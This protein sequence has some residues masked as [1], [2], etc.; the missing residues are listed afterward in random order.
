M[1]PGALAGPAPDTL[2]VRLPAFPAGSLNSPAWR[3][4]DGAAKLP[5]RCARAGSE[6]FMVCYL[7]GTGTLAVVGFAVYLIWHQAIMRLLGLVGTATEIALLLGA[8]AA[9]AI[10][11]IWTARVIRR[12]RAQA[13]ACTTCRFRCQQALQA[14][15]NLLVNRVD[16]RA[17][18]PAP[19]RPV[20]R[21]CQPAAPSSE[22]SGRRPARPRLPSP[23]LPAR[24]RLPA[25]PYPGDPPRSA[26][27]HPGLRRS[28][29]VQMAAGLVGSVAVPVAGRLRGSSL[30]R[31][32]L[33]AGRRGP[34]ID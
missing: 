28:S 7:P 17:L 20:T 21:A 30:G 10:A 23:W 31:T 14:R 33:G 9:V 4:I 16:R 15:P 13:G 3:R 18:P 24:P 5:R 12:R 1:A 8:A 26:S 34:V 29:V 11:L 25:R 19:S 2:A 32:G 22:C 6:R 27:S